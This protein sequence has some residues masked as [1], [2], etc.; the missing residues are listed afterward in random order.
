LFVIIAVIVAN[1]I[2]KS[3]WNG[4][5]TFI[6]FFILSFYFTKNFGE[7]DE[8]VMI[9]DILIYQGLVAVLTTFVLD[10]HSKNKEKAS[11][12]VISS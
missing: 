2:G 8:V 3:L 10:L 5:A 12:L 9:I 11:V 1:K 4:L 6:L 7:P